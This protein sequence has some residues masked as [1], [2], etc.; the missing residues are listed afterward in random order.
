VN[1]GQTAING[2][3][4]WIKDGTLHS[5]DT[6]Q[7]LGPLK[8]YDYCVIEIQ[9]ANERNDYTTLPFDQKFKEARAGLS[10]GDP[11]SQAIFVECC[12]QIAD[13]SDL[14]PS[15]AEG[16]IQAYQ[17]NFAKAVEFYSRLRAPTD[18]VATVYR[19]DEDGPLKP[20]QSIRR[21]AKAALAAGVKEKTLQGLVDLTNN[22]NDLP[23]L[24]S[25]DAQV[26]DELLNAQLAKIGRY[27][28]DRKPDPKGLANAIAIA[29]VTS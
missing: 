28:K 15:H 8:G 6:P 22:W 13:S 18:H 24:D 21:T 2:D 5:G 12:Q 3:N 27:A 16:L 14:T 25:P 11:L 26:T 1:C 7:S 20:Q 23:H 4:L 9:S 29:A 19:G 17:A 10:R